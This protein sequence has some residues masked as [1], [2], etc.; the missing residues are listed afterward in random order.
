MMLLCY[1]NKK[2]KIAIIN[3]IILQGNNTIQNIV[4]KIEEY[5]LTEQKTHL[6]HTFFE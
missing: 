1:L 4:K 2:F 5:E 3:I 6:K